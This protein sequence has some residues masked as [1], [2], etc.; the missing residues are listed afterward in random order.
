MT[1]RAVTILLKAREARFLVASVTGFV[2][3]RDLEVFMVSVDGVAM[4]VSASRFR[5]AANA[6][7]LASAAPDSD[8]RGECGKVLTQHRTRCASPPSAPLKLLARDAA[9]A[10]ARDMAVAADGCPIPC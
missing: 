5:K 4:S 1:R 8:D 9:A 2:S 7:V 6:I 3:E 10:A